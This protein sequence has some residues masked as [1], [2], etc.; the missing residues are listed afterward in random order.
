M[1]LSTIPAWQRERA[2]IL[3]ERFRVLAD[4]VER[5]AAPLVESLRALAAALD[6]S[7][8]DGGKRVLRA[9]H[10]TL[11]RLWYDWNNGARQAAALLH[12]YQTPSHTHRMPDALVAEIARMASGGTGGRDMHQNGIEAAGILKLLTRKWIAG[13]PIPGL[14]T[15]TEWWE[16]NHPTLPLPP[17]APKFPWSARTVARKI[18]TKAVRKWG[19][20]GRA[21]AQKHLPCL[22]RDYSKLRKC[23]LFTLDDVRLDLAGIDD[24]TGK[25]CEIKAYVLL[26]VASRS[27]VAFVLKPEHAIKAEDVDE[28]LAAGL[29]TDGFGIGVDYETHIWFERGTIACSEAAQRVLEAAIPNLRIH[30]TSMDGG[31]RWVGAAADKASGAARGKAVI[32]SL[33]RNLHRRLIDLPGQ[34]GNNRANQPSNLGIEDPDVKNVAGRK[35]ATLTAEAERLAQFR[36]SAIRYHQTPG[37]AAPDL[38]LPLLTVSRVREEFARCVKEHN[39]TAGHTMQGFHQV[40]E[41]ETLPGVWQRVS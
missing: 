21:A 32:E 24:L 11:T 17:V 31:V 5:E 18:G 37:Q 8:L 35:S 9:S 25:V 34:R 15:W 3:H 28:L 4:A 10:K 13:Q 23:E 27:V 20:I 39:T 2:A 33:N 14:G 30:R 6:G 16:T 22:E 19:N 26:E 38:K 40:T 41:A 1:K 12:S 7:P 29:Q 36:L